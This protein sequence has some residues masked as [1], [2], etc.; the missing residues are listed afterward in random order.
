M[1]Y[2]KKI[3][4]LA[5][6]MFVAGSIG[7]TVSAQEKLKNGRLGY[8]NF[9]TN[10]VEP[11]DQAIYSC[12]DGNYSWHETYD[13]GANNTTNYHQSFGITTQSGT[14]ITC[15]FVSWVD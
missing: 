15:T 12:T 8:F 7:F 13:F 10:T 1:T 3:G 4:T 9:E 6:L 5:L 11:T 2:L 14:H